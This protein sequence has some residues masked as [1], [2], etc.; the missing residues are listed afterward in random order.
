MYLV[1]LD[2]V[3]RYA[4][5]EGV[6]AIMRGALGHTFFPSPPELRQQ[7]DAAQRPHLEHA[8]RIRLTEEQ[9][10]ER[11]EEA[12]IRAGQTQAAR[13]RVSAAYER[14]CAGYQQPTEFV[15]TLDP[16]LV[17]QLPDAPST[18]SKARAA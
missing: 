1:A 3:T 16:G 10:R 7:C 14:F 11:R 18:F 8:R 13:A 12:A 9:E 2:G 6:K 5:S 15:P 4:L 17:A